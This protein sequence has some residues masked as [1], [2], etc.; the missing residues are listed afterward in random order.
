MAARLS[1]RDVEAPQVKNDD[2]N[3][4]YIRARIEGQWGSYSLRELL[5][6]KHGG[7]IAQWF[8]SRILGA[9]YLEECAIV[10]EAHARRM[11]AFLEEHVSQLV[12][13]K[14]PAAVPEEEK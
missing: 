6:A 10:T 11:V 9:I 12:R 1:H 14:Q 5:D 4:I 3:V 8:Y 2:L 13:L 7:Q